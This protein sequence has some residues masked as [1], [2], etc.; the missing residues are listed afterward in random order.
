MFYKQDEMA[1]FLVK[2][3]WFIFKHSLVVQHFIQATVQKRILSPYTVKR[4]LSFQLRLCSSAGFLLLLNTAG[5]KRG[6]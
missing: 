6:A 3:V 5:E 4:S 1:N 2:L